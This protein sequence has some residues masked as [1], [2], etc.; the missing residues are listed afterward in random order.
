MIK[1]TLIG[2]RNYESEHGES[3]RLAYYLMEELRDI[4]AGAPLYGV[5]IIKQ[6]RYRGGFSRERE[7]QG[8]ISYSR[9]LVLAM[10]DKLAKGMV[11][12]SAMGEVLDDLISEASC[13]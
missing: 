7:T 4:S 8:A 10:V 3:V 11:T 2:E 5:R 9:E 6:T 13:V 1:A 12:P